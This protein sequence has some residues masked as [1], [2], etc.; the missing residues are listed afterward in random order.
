MV[1]AGKKKVAGMHVSSLMTPDCS[2]A[3]RDRIRTLGQSRA[4]IPDTNAPLRH[5]LGR[6]S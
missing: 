4:A 2:H 3:T 1:E 6:T 5:T